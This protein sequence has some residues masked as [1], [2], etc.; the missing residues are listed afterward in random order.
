MKFIHKTNLTEIIEGL[1]RLLIVAHA[2]NHSTK[3]GKDDH[4]FKARW[5]TELA[6]TSNR[7]NAT[8]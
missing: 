8:K 2:C 3:A 1:R 4:K 6:L 7:D 5:V